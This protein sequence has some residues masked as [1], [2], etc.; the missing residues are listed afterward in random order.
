MGCV[1]GNLSPDSRCKWEVQAKLGRHIHYQ[2]DILW[3]AVRLMDLDA[4]PFTKP[5]N[6]DQ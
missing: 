4:N 1:E 5:T 3:G 6:M 2:I